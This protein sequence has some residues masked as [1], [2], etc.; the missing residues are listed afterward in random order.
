MSYRI[1]LQAG[2]NDNKILEGETQDPAYTLEDM[3]SGAYQ[4]GVRAIDAYDREGASGAHTLR[5]YPPRLA[6]PDLTSLPAAVEPGPVT[7]QWPTL[8]GADSYSIR[9]SLTGETDAVLKQ[10]RSQDPSFTLEN[11]APAEYQLSVSGID[12]HGR[13]GAAGSHSLHMLPPRLE[14]PDLSQ[15]PS[16]AEAGSV[17]LQWPVLEGA[18]S[19]ITRLGLV[20]GG[21]VEVYSTKGAALTLENLQPGIYQLSIRGL[22]SYGREGVTGMY[23][24]PVNRKSR[25]VPVLGRPLFGPGWMDFHWSRVEGAWGYRLLIARDSHFQNPLFEHIGQATQ[26]RLPFYWNGRLY[27]RVDALFETEPTESHSGIYRIELPW[28]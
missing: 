13:T 8:E 7:L 2:D 5:V 15:L 28:R 1:R 22:D 18:V 23:E 24:L 11:L 27:V 21:D 6:A 16:T 12:A 4:L 17:S 3:P 9:L 25:A 14:A 10:H 19:Y 20:G 26:W